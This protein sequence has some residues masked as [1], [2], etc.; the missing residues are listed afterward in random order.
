MNFLLL[1]IGLALLVCGANW[2]VDAASSLARKLGLSEFFIGLVIVGF[3]TSFP[4]LVV[5]LTGAVRE[6]A[7]VAVGNVLGSNIFNVFVILGVTSLVRPLEISREN[8]RRDIPVLFVTTLLVLGLGLGGRFFGR[9]DDILSRGEAAILLTVFVLYITSCFLSGDSR[10]VNGEKTG[11][12]TGFAVLML[13]P[14]LG[15]LIGGGELFVDAAVNIARNFGVSDKFISVTILAAG[16]S[17]PEL[18]TNIAAAAKGRGEMALGNIIGSNVFNL[19]LI[20]G[21]SALITPLSFANINV[22]DITALILST[23]LIPVLGGKRSQGVML[24]TIFILYSIY[25]IIQL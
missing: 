14:A 15:A 7:D 6:N 20:L 16:T 18:V 2:L 19:L 10:N 1:V 9:N 8:L 17:L 3:G 22:V 23:L 11:I 13:L 24:L 25:L 12:S 21:C 4:E 5:S